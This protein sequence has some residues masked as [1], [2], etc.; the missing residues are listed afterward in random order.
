MTYPCG[1]GKRYIWQGYPRGALSLMKTESDVTL[2]CAYAHRLSSR[3]EDRESFRLRFTPATSPIP[4]EQMKPETGKAPRHLY[5]RLMLMSCVPANTLDHSLHD[6]C[7]PTSMPTP[8]LS[9]I[10]IYH[11]FPSPPCFFIPSGLWELSPMTHVC[12]WR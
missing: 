12:L 1:N 9:V 11:L 6:A 10:A 8:P 4:G 3:I 7:L 5:P 2:L